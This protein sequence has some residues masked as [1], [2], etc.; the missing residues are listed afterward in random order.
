MRKAIA[1]LPVVSAISPMITG[2][3]APPT[4]V[5]KSGEE[6]ICIYTIPNCSNISFVSLDKGRFSNS[7]SFKYFPQ[8]KSKTS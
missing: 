6:A 8:T 1:M 5:M 4:I 3:T 2:A 7:S